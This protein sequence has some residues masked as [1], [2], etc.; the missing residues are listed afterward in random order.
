MTEYFDSHTHIQFAAY[1]KDRDEVI[2]KT[3][4]ES[5]GFVNVGTN[6]KTSEEAVGLSEKYE[7]EPIYA[8]VGLHPVHTYES[9][10]HDEHE[11]EAGEETEEFDY[12]FYRQLTLKDKVVSVGECGLDYFR[13]EGNAGEIKEKQIK[14]FEEQIKL[15]REIKKPLMIHC[16][17]AFDDLIEVLARNFGLPAPER[18]GIVHF[19]SGTKEHAEKLL[20]MGFYFTFG[21]V[22]T[23][24]RD[25][26]ELVEMIPEDRLLLET[27]AP[28]VSPR[29]HR[30]KR[31]EPVYI[32]ETYE[33]VSKLKGV[34]IEKLKKLI[35]ENNERI[36]GIKIN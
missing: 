13:L 35:L 25:Y 9:G 2:Q 33:R 5:V 36:F 14:A 31:N 34:P 1:D 8:S 12:D 28:Y 32:K 21:G 27:D 24:T 19:F 26:D 15:A 4:R 29:S 6:R 20:K 7:S 30:G 17:D 3:L 10:Y 18:P 22:V 11:S 23:L 16:R